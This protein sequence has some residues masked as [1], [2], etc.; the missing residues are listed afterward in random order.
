MQLFKTLTNKSHLSSLEDPSYTSAKKL[1]CV[2]APRLVVEKA[3][4]LP[5][6]IF[7]DIF[8]THEYSSR[9]RELKLSNTKLKR[10]NVRG[11][12]YDVTSLPDTIEEFRATRNMS[13]DPIKHATKGVLRKVDAHNICLDTLT[14]E[15]NKTNLEDLS[16]NTRWAITKEDIDRLIDVL[17]VNKT[18][19]TVKLWYD[20]TIDTSRCNMNKLRMNPV[21]RVVEI[22]GRVHLYNTPASR[23]QMLS[24]LAL[25]LQVPLDLTRMLGALLY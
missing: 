19:K 23:E 1:C 18:L 17:A 5:N 11:H 8:S 6:L 4:L 9:A 22:N 13:C 2:D 7:V 10:L 20:C 25:S 16:V 15:I 21:I 24:L 12:G 14:S 3:M